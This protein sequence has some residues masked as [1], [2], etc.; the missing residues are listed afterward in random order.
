MGAHSLPNECFLSYFFFC[1]KRSFLQPVESRMALEMKVFTCIKEEDRGRGQ[2]EKWMS[3]GE[4]K[5]HPTQGTPAAYPLHSTPM[6]PGLPTPQLPNR[7]HCFVPAGSPCARGSIKLSDKFLGPKAHRPHCSASSSNTY[8]SLLAS[9]CV[10]SPLVP[11]Q[12]ILVVACEH[13]YAK[14]REAVFTAWH[15]GRT[16]GSLLPGYK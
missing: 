16:H 1:L 13:H 9:P 12:D 7:R 2:E 5:A 15:G 11:P 10:C 4:R 8:P 6:P 14:L 3:S